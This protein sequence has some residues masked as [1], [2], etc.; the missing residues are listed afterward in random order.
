MAVQVMKRE[1]EEK[2]GVRTAAAV[3]ADV[4]HLRVAFEPMVMFDCKEI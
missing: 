4:R 3:N 2:E 1:E